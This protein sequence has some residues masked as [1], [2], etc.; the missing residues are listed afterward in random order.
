MS[1]FVAAIG[2]GLIP[3]SMA[4]AE[5]KIGGKFGLMRASPQISQAVKAGW[6]RKVQRGQGKRFSP[7]TDGPGGPSMTGGKSRADGTRGDGGLSLRLPGGGGIPQ[8]RHGGTG[9]V[10][11]KFAG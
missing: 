1:S 9:D 11:E 6:F 2:S 10:D 5:A 8:L 3:L 7:E 4:S